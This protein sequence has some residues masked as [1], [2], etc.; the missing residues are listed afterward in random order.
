MHTT[1]DPHGHELETVVIV[2]FDRA[3]G[4]VRGTYMHSSFRGARDDA[5][6]RRRN[7]LRFVNELAGP[8]GA[9][10]VDTVELAADQLRGR[11]IERVDPGTREVLTRPQNRAGHPARAPLPR[12]S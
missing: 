3:S 10:A 5:A 12:R 1:K 4:E 6:V 7:T 9:Q 8:A 2:A 11:V